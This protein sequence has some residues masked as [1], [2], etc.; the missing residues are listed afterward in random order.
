M[1]HYHGGP[2]TPNV[3]A[4]KVWAG[5]HAFVSFSAPHQL[6]IAMEVCQSF[7]VDNGAFSSWKKGVSVDW[8]MY[9]KW[10][11]SFARAANF[12]WAIIPDII[13]GSEEENDALIDEWP[14]GDYGVP[15]WHMHESVERLQNLCRNWPRICIGSSGE[16]SVVGNAKWRVR[17]DEA[18]SSISDRRG[19]VKRKIHGLRMLNPK[20]FVD[21]PLSSADST[22]VARNI[23]IDMAWKGTN[24]PPTKEWRAQVLAARIEQHNSLVKWSGK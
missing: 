24:V 15:V 7:A 6:E 4:A 11:A 3:V 17:M 8:G 10:V 21:Y 5:R 9:Y 22:N 18:I 14:L 12:D 23:G 2:I 16:F 20:V 13:D 19:F 1:I